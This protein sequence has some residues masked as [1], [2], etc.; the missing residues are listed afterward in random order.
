MPF[1]P[2]S[3]NLCHKV[4]EHDLVLAKAWA[5]VARVASFNLSGHATRLD[6]QGCE[7]GSVLTPANSLHHSGDFNR[8]FWTRDTLALN[9]IPASLSPT[10]HCKYQT[11][12]R[13]R[14]R[15]SP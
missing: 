9:L 8:F 1:M 14:V 4:C 13:A 5:P 3:N 12:T 11:Q 7:S 2:G 15:F 6:K 10:G